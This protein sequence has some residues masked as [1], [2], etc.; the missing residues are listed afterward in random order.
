MDVSI[1]LA[2]LFGFYLLIVALLYFF[3][4]EFLRKVMKD[5]YKFPALVAVTS[6][7]NLFIGLLIILNHNI[8]EFSWK[9]VI[10]LIGYL[11]LL[12]GGL[13]LFAP[14]WGEALA[15]KFTKSRNLFIYS[16]IISL[17]LGLYLLY[18]AFL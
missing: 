18:N 3:R 15:A 6:I 2:K 16:G 7:I 11:T 9:V 14:A 4:G 17:A 1:F 5:F 12:K 10:T 8:W 13:N